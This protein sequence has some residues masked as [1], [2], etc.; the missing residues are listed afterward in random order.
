MPIESDVDPL[1]HHQLPFPKEALNEIIIP[2]AM[3]KDDL[4]VPQA[5]NVWFRPVCL[6]RS[7]G[8]W[9]LLLKV[10]KAGVLSRHRHPQG[11][12]EFVLKGTGIIRMWLGGKQVYM[13]SN[14]LE[15]R[16]HWWCPK[17]WM[18]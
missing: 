9:T 13:C 11:V 2:D 12:H 14:L 17:A 4:R 1:T 5:E 16:I 18:K 10:R 3:L 7:Q 8:Y 15:K 6:N